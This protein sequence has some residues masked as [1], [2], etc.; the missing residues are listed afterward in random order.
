[1]A[2]WPS[3]NADAR[4]SPLKVVEKQWQRERTSHIHSRP[5]VVDM[6]S[7]ITCRRWAS[8]SLACF[9]RRRMDFRS[10]AFA[11][12]TPSQ[13]VGPYGRSYGRDGWGGKCTMQRRR[14]G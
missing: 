14:L 1:M 10:A 3:A 4:A 12:T 2:R 7:V 11:I 8:A 9:S 6:R 5:K 13:A